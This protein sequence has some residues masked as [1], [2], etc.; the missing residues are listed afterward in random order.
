MGLQIRDVGAGRHG[1]PLIPYFY[2][3]ALELGKMVS[4]YRGTTQDHLSN[5]QSIKV[6]V[7]DGICNLQRY[8]WIPGLI[9][10]FNFLYRNFNCFFISIEYQT[11]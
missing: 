8:S 2:P 4:T 7:D 6:S 3:F 9:R 10:P 11:L 1:I 5:Y